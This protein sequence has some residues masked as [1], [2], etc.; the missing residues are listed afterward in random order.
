MGFGKIFKAMKTDDT[1]FQDLESFGKREVLQRAMEKLWILVCQNSKKNM[2]KWIQ[3]SAL[4]SIVDVFSIHCTIYD[5]KH[6][7]PKNHKI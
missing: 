2:L 3:V 7:P 6:N 1:I 4:L 5:I